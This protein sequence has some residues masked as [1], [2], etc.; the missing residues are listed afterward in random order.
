MH[1]YQL[2]TEGVLI[3]GKQMHAEPGDHDMEKSQLQI[4]NCDSQ[5]TR[6]TECA[7][8][9]NINMKYGYSTNNLAMVMVTVPSL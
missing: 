8:K 5:I 3:F 1:Y 4:A 2:S 9:S 7:D 6:M